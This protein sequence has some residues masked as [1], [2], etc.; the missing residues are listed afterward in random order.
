MS[1]LRISVGVLAAVALLAAAACGDDDPDGARFEAARYDGTY[2]GDWT[3]ERTGE[4]GPVSIAIDIDEAS[5]SADLTIDFGGDYLGP[6]T[7]RRPG[8]RAPTTPSAPARSARAP[9][10]AA[11]T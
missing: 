11:T 10:S 5:R 3:N 7:L 2:R 1:R 8:S 4:S 6:A 9:S